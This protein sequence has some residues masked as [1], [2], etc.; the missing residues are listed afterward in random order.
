MAEITAVT[1]LCL[2]P[3]KSVACAGQ[4][5]EL[6]RMISS[7]GNSSIPCHRFPSSQRIKTFS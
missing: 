4:L 7:S 6:G 3:Q 1:S 5:V 2:S